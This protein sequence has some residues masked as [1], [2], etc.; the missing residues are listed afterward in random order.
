M[1]VAA[2]L[3]GALVRDVFV[4][5]FENLSSAAKKCLFWK[6]L[7]VALFHNFTCASRI[8]CGSGSSLSQDNGRVSAVY[9]CA[10]YI[11]NYE[12]KSLVFWTRIYIMAFVF[13]EKEEERTTL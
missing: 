6:D 5:L 9:L 12:H 4:G 8:S 11:F 1:R 13:G 7:V 2:F 3:Y 10:F